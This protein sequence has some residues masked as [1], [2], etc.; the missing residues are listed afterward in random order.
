MRKFFRE[1]KRDWTAFG[2]LFGALLLRMF[3]FGIAYYPQLDDYIQHRFYPVGTDYLQIALDRGLFASRPLAG[4][5]DL[6][7]WGQMPFVLVAILLAA[8]Y[9]ASGVLYG[10]LFRKY[11]GT[12]VTFLVVYALLPVG[13]EG[14]YWLA[15][16]TRIV[17]PL[18]FSALALLAFDGFCETKNRKHL[19]PY[20]LWSALS[21]CFY[22]QLLVLSLALSGMVMLLWLMKKQWH[23]LWGLLIFVPVGFYALVTGY[24]SSLNTG[25]LSGRM[26]LML[27]WMEGFFETH[28][29]RLM[30]QMGECFWGG[31]LAITGKGFVRGLELLFRERVWP[32]LL[33]PPVL[34]GLARM[35]GADGRGDFRIW[36]PI[37]GILA[38]LAPLTPFVVLKNPWF[39]LRNILP[40]L[41]GLAI[42]AD[43]LV[44]LV[45]KNR[46]ALFAAILAAVCM[47]A[48][49]SEIYDFREVS[50]HNERVAQNILAGDF[51]WKGKVG[52]LGLSQN[53]VQEQNYIYHDHI[54][55]SHASN[56]ALEGLLRYYSGGMLD[57]KPTPM[58]TDETYYWNVWN[59]A[60]RDVTAYD[61]LYLYDHE[62]G[63]L[64]PLT[65]EA[66]AGAWK[67][68]Y[69]D[70]TPCASVWEDSEGF[71]HI[72]FEQP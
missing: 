25:E 44:R 60:S 63:T 38:F 16:S 23:A 52:I 36:A 7:L 51:G 27:P 40:S 22:E 56:W 69:A 57:Y 13:L 53:Y 3:W 29:P 41:L 67:L 42:V 6:L 33:L 61:A 15:A 1:N 49:V 62:A 10:R 54:I 19:I 8:M 9:A 71:G 21:L 59:K 4:I 47:I 20:V 64:E 66:G 30:K 72:E 26:G 43:W 12:G 17:P 11:F 35:K 58:A 50:R 2:V 14:N 32:I 68:F 46:S 37:F 31:N 70:G 65:V 39:S 18:L 5:T 28:M 55:S 45:L 24:F 48:S 34:V